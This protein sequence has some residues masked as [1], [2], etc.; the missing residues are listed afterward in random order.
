MDPNAVTVLI[1]ITVFIGI[2]RNLGQRRAGEKSAYS[3]FN[4]GCEALLGATSAEDMDNML[5][6][7]DAGRYGGGG[8][9]GGVR[10]G[11]GRDRHAEMLESVRREIRG[12]RRAR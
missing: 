12:G 4:A 8:G 5:R 6:R 10:V 9:D 3:V 2:W 7:R 1:C 11:G